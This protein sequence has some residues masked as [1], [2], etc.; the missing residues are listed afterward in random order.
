MQHTSMPTA[1][2]V[3]PKLGIDQR[4]YIRWLRCKAAAHVR[5]DRKRCDYEIMGEEYR[6]LIHEAV[7]AHGTHDY[8]TGEK[9]DWSLVS[10]YCNEASQ[11]GRAAYKA[12]FAM[13]P[14]VDH[15]MGDNGRYDFVICA[16][17]TNDCKS[18]LA[19]PDFV[20]FCRKVIAKADAS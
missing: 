12:G 15:I 13:L 19:Y 11:A 1:Y 4:T 16:W 9:L 14:T 10:T 6:R 17:R 20:D 8:Y 2:P 18:D 7:T 5:R 3:A